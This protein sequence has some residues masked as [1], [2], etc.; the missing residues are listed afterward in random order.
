MFVDFCSELSC[1]F[2]LPPY[3]EF[4]HSL[5][6]R[7]DVSVL[8]FSNDLLFVGTIRG[9]LIVFKIKEATNVSSASPPPPS[10]DRPPVAAPDHRR[11]TPVAYQKSYKYSFAANAYC[12]PHPIVALH[13]S[14]PKRGQ[15]YMSDSPLLS[16][17]TMNILV[18]CGESYEG[19]K[20]SQL[21]LFE[22]ML[23]PPTSVCSTPLPTYS[24]SLPSSKPLPRSMSVVSTSSDHYLPLHN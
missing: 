24:S 13:T 22:L 15:C 8:H 20:S 10:Q 12:G 3:S 18:I 19:A 5:A 6:L 17:T 1:N 21:C 11:A 9:D 4:H 14:S 2:S 16:P 23:S 7:P